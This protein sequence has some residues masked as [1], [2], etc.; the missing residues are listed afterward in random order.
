MRP[1]CLY[2]PVSRHNKGGA[3]IVAEYNVLIA[4]VGGQGVI[5]ISELLGNAAVRDG[6]NVRGSE[7]L[8]MA[9][10][11]GPVVSIIRLGSDVYGPLIPA[12]KG[13]ILIAL[14]PSEALRNSTHLS[15]SSKVI[16]N[17]ETTVPFTVPLG[18]S[19]Y[20]AMDEI[21]ARLSKVSS[22]IISL[23]AKE[24]AVEAGSPLSA[25]IV[26]LG[27]AFGA[28]Q[29]PI[30]LDTIKE[31]IQAHFPAKL[32]TINIKAFDLGYQQSRAHHQ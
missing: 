3:R 16:L 23:N 21:I 28:G 18:E 30:K 6:I 27:A 13:D 20:P 24:I 29:L 32:G 19:T 14:E 9:V 31:A 12:G 26:M 17:T 15:Q 5:L 1:L 7:V 22:G 11:G 2:L 25:N 10:R 8:G 4:G